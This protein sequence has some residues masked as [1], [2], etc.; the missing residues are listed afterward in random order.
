VVTEP[1]PSPAIQDEHTGQYRH[2]TSDQAGPDRQINE[3]T[4]AVT[5]SRAGQTQH[6]DRRPADQVQ[7]HTVK[8][9]DVTPEPAPRRDRP[10][11]GVSTFHDIS[12]VPREGNRPN[13]PELST[14]LSCRRPRAAA[15]AEIVT[16]RGLD[17]AVPEHART[18]YSACDR[19]TRLPCI[20]RLRPGSLSSLGFVHR[21]GSS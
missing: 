2:G 14:I 21:P 6:R 5:N 1:G 4:P 12:A 8:Q 7:L 3:P 10:I 16:L 11:F 20:G 19:A 13:R 9:L 18:E 15:A 17:S